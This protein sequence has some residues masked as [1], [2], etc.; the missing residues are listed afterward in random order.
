M[1]WT[2][3]MSETRRAEQHG[4]GPAPDGQVNLLAAG[5]T[6]SAPGTN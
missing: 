5:L 6:E 1:D 2:D 3:V 4:P